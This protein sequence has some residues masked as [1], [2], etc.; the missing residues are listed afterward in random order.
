MPAISARHDGGPRRAIWSLRA[1]AELDKERVAPRRATNGRF[2]TQA[3]HPPPTDRTQPPRAL[4][5]PICRNAETRTRMSTTDPR[6]RRNGLTPQVTS[7]TAHM[8]SAADPTAATTVLPAAPE[9]NTLWMTV[10]SR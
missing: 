2:R 3:P 5:H 1:E 6:P 9:R 7:R 4:G 10:A 8:T